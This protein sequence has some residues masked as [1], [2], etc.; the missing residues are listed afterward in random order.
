MNNAGA[1]AIAPVFAMLIMGGPLTT[2]WMFL[3]SMHLIL[4]TPLIDSS[5]PA[6]AHY[7]FKDYLSLIRLSFGPINKYLEIWQEEIGISNFQLLQEDHPYYSVLFNSCGYK[8]NYIRN[9]FI[10]AV[11]FMI[12]LAIWCG[13]CLK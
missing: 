6:N 9:L 5:M 1:L 2:V 11:I 12:L 13:F 4:H 7:F 10:F 8:H 3:N